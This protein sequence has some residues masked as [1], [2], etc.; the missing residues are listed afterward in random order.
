MSWRNQKAQ[1]TCTVK[2]GHIL[3]AFKIQAGTNQEQHEDLC[4]C[5]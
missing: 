3:N 1:V 5:L 4:F 2:L